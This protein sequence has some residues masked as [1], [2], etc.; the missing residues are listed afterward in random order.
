MNRSFF[1]LPLIGAVLPA[2]ARE[3][4]NV[5]FI[6]GDDVGYGDLSCYGAEKISTPHLDR[7]AAREDAVLRMRTVRPQHRLRPVMPC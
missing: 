5:L 2:S 7:L 3:K 6:I 1:L 4:P